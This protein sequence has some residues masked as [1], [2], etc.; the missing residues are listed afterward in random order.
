MVTATGSRPDRVEILG[1]PVDALDMADTLRRCEELIATGGP[2][3]HMAVNVAKLVAARENAELRD[4]IQQSAVINADG[5]GIVWAA[6]LL[7]RPLPERVAGIDLMQELIAVAAERGY[8]PFI[9]GAKREV[10]DRAVE[11]LKQRHPAL[12]FAG[13]RDGYFSAAEEAEVCE[14]IRRS[15]ADMLFVA[16]GTP[17]K[18]TFLAQ[19]AD[20][21]GVPLLVGVGGAVD[22]IA[23]VTK[24]APRVWQKLGVEWLYRMLQEP[25]RMFRRYAVTNARF[26]VIL[27][28]ELARPTRTK[29]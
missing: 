12:E 18:E 28:R 7:G 1:C 17:R 22:V 2:H 6:R 8:R 14:E 5:Q 24:R 26:A 21:L 29:K 11:V 13:V 20:D 23:G 19:H 16:M 25:R 27:G 3:Q 9:L 15:K 4:A 10:L